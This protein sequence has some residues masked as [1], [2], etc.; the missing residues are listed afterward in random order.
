MFLEL[1]SGNIDI[2]RMKPDQYRKAS[3]N[4]MFHKA[5]IKKVVLEPEYT[6][7][8]YNLI[9]DIF[10]DVKVRR[11]ITMAIDREEIVKKILLNFGT[12]VTG[13]FYK[14]NWAYDKS[15]KQI[16]YNLEKAKSLLKEAGYEDINGDGILEKDMGTH[17]LELSFTL[18]TNTGNKDR[19]LTAE[20]IKKALKKVGIKVVVKFEEWTAF[21]N[22][23]IDTKKFDAILLAWGVSFDPDDTFTVWNS[24]EIPDIKNGKFGLNSTSFINK[25][26]N[27]LFKK[28]RI[29]FDKEKRKACYLKFIKSSQTF[30]HLH[31]CIQHKVFLQLIK[32]LKMCKS[33]K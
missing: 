25:E 6:Y 21:I 11:A 28:G 18:M 12:V 24:E 33:M 8:G 16:E 9:R 10:K 23:Y 15:I 3:D 29:T 27:D 17:Y 1:L 22:K 4:P 13:P 30:S 7:L 20:F 14:N 31:L 2:M 5:F 32:K 19:E 26:V